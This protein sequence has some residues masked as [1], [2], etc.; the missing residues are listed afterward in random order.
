MV[1]RVVSWCV[2]NV[3]CAELIKDVFNKRET[4]EE[5]SAFQPLTTVMLFKSFFQK[6]ASI[7]G[8]RFSFAQ[9]VKAV[10]WSNALPVAL[11]LGRW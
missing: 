11:F 7:E 5:M 9:F 6:H 8:K 1:E 4:Y 10:L 3:A 2:F